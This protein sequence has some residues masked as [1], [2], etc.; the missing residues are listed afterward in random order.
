VAR[1]SDGRTIEQAYQLDV[2]GYRVYS[3]DW[4]VGK[5]KPPL[6]LSVDLYTEY[7]ALWLQWVTENEVLFAELRVLVCEHNMLL[8]DC[9]ASGPVSQARALAELLNQTTRVNRL[10]E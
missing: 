3:D 10:F 8:T 9:F 7:K 1:L 4:R 5:G 6:D 2:K